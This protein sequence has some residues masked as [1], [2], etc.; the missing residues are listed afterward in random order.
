MVSLWTPGSYNTSNVLIRRNPNASVYEPG[1]GAITDTQS[2]LIMPN[3]NMTLG[4]STTVAVNA[5]GSLSKAGK[6][7]AAVLGVM[8]GLVFGGGH[9]LLSATAGGLLGYYGGHY[10][11]NLIEKALQTSQ[12][13]ETVK[14]TLPKAATS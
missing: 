1:P 14:E 3:A 10:I 9:R 8:A 2:Y 12:A 11:V 6:R 4:D 13:I 5:L 7:G